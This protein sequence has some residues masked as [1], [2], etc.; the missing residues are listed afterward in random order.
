MITLFVMVDEREEKKK[1]SIFD[2]LKQTY[3]KDRPTGFSE[4][5][6]QTQMFANIPDNQ[7]GHAWTLV[8]PSPKDIAKDGF[9]IITDPQVLLGNI[10]NEK[11][12]RLYQIDLFFLTNMLSTAIHDKMMEFVF[13]PL[14]TIFKSEV[15]ITATLEGSERAY[16]A[17]TVPMRTGKSKGFRI[18]GGKK[19][20]KEP[21][22]YVIPQE[23]EGIY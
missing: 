6:Q 3:D 12:L 16:Q 17:F 8:N 20:K 18:L 15:R 11:S 1:A 7:F 14:W 10:G 2:E 9:N 22:D 4:Y 13:E 5:T 21:I 23:E 19:K